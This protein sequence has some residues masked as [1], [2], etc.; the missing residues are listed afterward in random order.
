MDSPSL[1]SSALAL[2]RV[3]TNSDSSEEMKTAVKDGKCLRYNGIS[4]LS[5]NAESLLTSK[6]VLEF[7]SSDRHYDPAWILTINSREHLIP[8]WLT[9]RGTLDF[10]GFTNSTVAEIWTYI[11]ENAPPTKDTYPFASAI[12]EFWEAVM[13]WFDHNVAH[14]I[15][16]EKDIPESRRTPQLILNFLGIRNEV[17][18]LPMRLHTAGQEIDD[19]F[20]L[21]R[22]HTDIVPV[23]TKRYITRR[24]NVLKK[25]NGLV[26]A[27]E[28]GWWEKIAREMDWMTPMDSMEAYTTTKVYL[29]MEKILEIGGM[30]VSNTQRAGY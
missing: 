3:G 25:M 15:R 5:N 14:M 8:R 1:T 18:G 20:Q 6:E 16:H 9:S 24:W 27:Q 10:V 30:I 17:Q 21:N 23:W 2:S 26:L 29:P 22:I 19:A 7:V 4:V 12:D 13:T 11:K 28:E